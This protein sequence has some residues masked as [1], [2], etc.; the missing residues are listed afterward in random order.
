MASDPDLFPEAETRRLTLRCVRF[1][2]ASRISEMM[3]PVVSQWVASWPIPF[4]LEMAA[5]RITNARKAADGETALPCAIERRSDGALLGWIG[6]TRDAIDH[7]RGVL[8]YWLGE[9]HH[10]HGYMREAGPALV[11]LAFRHLSLKTI[12]AAA[13]PQ[14]AA[15]FAVLRRCGMEQV[16]ERMIFAMAR[17]REER[18]LVYEIVRQHA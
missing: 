5:E 6:V 2:D 12:E 18:C 7:R 3:T 8:G 14:N 15:S 9:E 17:N 4:T 10:G 1:E 16:G 11:D 13:Q